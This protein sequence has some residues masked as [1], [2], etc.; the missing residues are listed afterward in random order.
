MKTEYTLTHHAYER[1][2]QRVGKGKNKSAALNWIVQA[3]KNSSY[4]GETDGYRYYKYDEFKIVIG[5]KNK[6]VTISYF[7]DS[8]IKE[9]KKEM[10]KFIRNKFINKLKP[11]YRIKKGLQIEV[12]EAKIRQLKVNNPTTKAIIQN[13]IT[14][15]ESQL[16]S[17]IGSIDNIIKAAEHYN[18]PS[19]ELVKG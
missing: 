16:V 11:Y 12:Y 10:N 15:L 2:K 8:H 18:V 3:I 5:E 17:T 19:N 14:E 4:L 13:E 7:N 9:F 6:V 1:Y